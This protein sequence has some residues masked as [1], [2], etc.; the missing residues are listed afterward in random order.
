[1]TKKNDDHI[2]L[3]ALERIY[4]E[5]DDIRYGTLLWVYNSI[6]DAH[7]DDVIRLEIKMGKLAKDQPCYNWTTIEEQN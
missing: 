7:D 3:D 4:G 2:F 1:M 5:T 6:T